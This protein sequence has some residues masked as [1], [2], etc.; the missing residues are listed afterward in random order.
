MAK[1]L[2]LDLRTQVLAAISS[3]LS[4]GRAATRFGVSALSAIRW[5]ALQGVQGDAKPKA[6]GGRKTQGRRSVA[7]LKTGRM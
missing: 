3:D 6:A 5:R 1:A 4:C 7:A 2:C